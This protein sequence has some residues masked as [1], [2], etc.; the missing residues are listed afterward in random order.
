[1]ACSRGGAREPPKGNSAIP[2]C[3]RYYP[4]TPPFAFPITLALGGTPIPRPVTFFL[5]IRPTTL[6]QKQ[7]EDGISYWIMDDEHMNLKEPG[8]GSFTLYADGACSPNPGKGGYGVILMGEGT[9][10]ELSGGFHRT[11][12]NR[13]ELF[14]VIAGLS[15]LQPDD[16]LVTVYSDSQYVVN[17]YAGG[18][19]RKWKANGWKRG[20]HPALNPDLWDAL[21][22]LCDKH[23]VTFQWVRGHSEHPENTRCDELAVQARQGENLPADEFYENMEK[24]EVKVEQLSLFDWGSQ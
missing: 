6:V 7:T 23:R 17:M 1:M 15:S 19:A 9:R 11:T 20:K 10:R 22:T 13:M 5:A 18:Y 2:N 16:L 24:A 4:S 21:L 12:N 14:S 8:L 3:K